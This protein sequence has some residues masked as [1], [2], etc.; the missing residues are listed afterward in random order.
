LNEDKAKIENCKKLIKFF[1]KQSSEYLDQAKFHCGLI[2]PHWQVIEEEITETRKS[3]E[4]ILEGL[5]VKH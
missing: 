5:E 3:I 1:L 2:Y 4:K